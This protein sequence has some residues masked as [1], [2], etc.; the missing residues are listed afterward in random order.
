[1]FRAIIFQLEEAGYGRGRSENC[2]LVCRKIP[3]A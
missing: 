2:G 1:V 3:K